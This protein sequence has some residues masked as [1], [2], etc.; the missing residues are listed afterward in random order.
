MLFWLGLALAAL[1][2]LFLMLSGNP[3]LLVSGPSGEDAGMI[4][5]A[6]ALAAYAIF[7]FSGRS[8]TIGQSLRHLAI[9]LGIAL[10][11]VAVYAYRGEVTEIANRVV[12]ELVP[13]GQSVTLET[14]AAG[15]R[16]V[17]IRRR[18]DG[19][20]VARAD[21]NGAG[22]T[23]LVDTGASTVVLKPAD[24]ERCGID[25]SR[26]AYTIAV[27][28]ANGTA[29]AAA[30]RLRAISVGGIEVREVDALVAKPGSLNESLLGMSFLRRLRSYEFTGE[31]LTLR[32]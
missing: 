17:R 16:S 8:G 29:Y 24:A 30:T 9:W 18:P 12:G 32:G 15:Q 23:M 6:I 26:L 31:F 5:F 25:T 21:I 14:D 1:I 27:Q 2:G 3:D 22:V 19:H 7:L 20:F 28:T 10:A 13:P 4:A 11:L